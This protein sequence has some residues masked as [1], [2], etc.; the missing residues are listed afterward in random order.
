MVSKSLKLNQKKDLRSLEQIALEL[1]EGCSSG[2]MSTNDIE[3]AQIVL[4]K[5][6]ARIFESN[7]DRKSVV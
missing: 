5:I 4:N 1:D 7:K 2:V 3:N 6:S